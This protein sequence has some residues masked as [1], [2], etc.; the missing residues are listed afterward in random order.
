MTVIGLD[1]SG[2]STLLNHFKPDDQQNPNIGKLRDF[3]GLK[4]NY[5]RAGLCT[6]GFIGGTMG[7]K[8]I[9]ISQ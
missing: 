7:K 2:K 5:L 6:Q 9:Y 8:L 4:R 1:N 3:S